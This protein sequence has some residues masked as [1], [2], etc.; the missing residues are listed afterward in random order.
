MEAFKKWFASKSKRTQSLLGLFAVGVVVIGCYLLF[1]SIFYVS[2][3]DAF[4]EGH[5]VP[6]SPKVASH[7]EKVLVIDNQEVKEGDLLVELDARDFLAQQAMAKANV[8]AAQAELDESQRDLKRYTE[9]SKTEEVS[10]QQLDRATLRFET[11]Q[12][13]VAQT[14]AELQKAELLV[15]YTKIAAPMAGSVAKKTVEEGAF[16]QP[17]QPLLAIVAHEKWV[18]ANFKETQLTH[19][20]PGQKVTIK[21]DAFPGKT[22]HGHVD[23]IQRGSGAR[24]SLLPPENA[25]GN[26]VKVVQRI[27]VKI[28]FDTE[29]DEDRP[30]GVGMSVIPKIKIR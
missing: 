29:T 16:V 7:V 21:I 12:A 23:S 6:I 15:S 18:V 4:I 9:L 27:P 13:R 5:V 30:L 17:G 10:K 26:F 19:V 8:Q 1:E 20:K 3:D 11:A 28:V 24:F 25:T 22:F 2:T 14:G